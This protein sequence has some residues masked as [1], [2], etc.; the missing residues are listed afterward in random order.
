MLPTYTV[1]WLQMHKH[2]PIEAYAVM[3]VDVP[4]FKAVARQSDAY[5]C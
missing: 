1:R 4:T 5:L 3:D 2:Y